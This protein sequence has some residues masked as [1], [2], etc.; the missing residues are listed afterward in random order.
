[1]IHC[2]EQQ[3]F[4][5]ATSYE[6]NAPACMYVLYIHHAVMYNSSVTCQILNIKDLI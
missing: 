2:Q 3:R 1:M 6:R 4:K 5:K